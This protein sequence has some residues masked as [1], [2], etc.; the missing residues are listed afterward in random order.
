MKLETSVDWFIR[1]VLAVWLRG[2]PVL[3]GDLH[4]TVRNGV[5]EIKMNKVH[6]PFT[7]KLAESP[8]TSFRGNQNFVYVY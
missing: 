6:N 1:Y 5:P 2:E 3:I 4:S 7:L 8:L